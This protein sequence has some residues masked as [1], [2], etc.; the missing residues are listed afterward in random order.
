VS[1]TENVKNLDRQL[2]S[3]YYTDNLSNDEQIRSFKKNAYLVLWETLI[4]SDKSSIVFIIWQVLERIMD[5][6]GVELEMLI[7]LSSQICQVIPRDFARELE[8]NEI[9]E[10]FVK[11]LVDTLNGSMEPS[12]DCPG[13]R[14]VILEQAISL[15]EY[16]SRYASCFKDRR[17]MEALSVVE[18]TASDV[19]KYNLFLGDTGLLEASEPLPRLVARAK[20]LLAAVHSA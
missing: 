6:E 5:A 11:R 1:K 9:K 4:F 17:M 15:L 12:A 19:E 7:G 18:E 2:I 3:T 16:D 8:H 13:I 10:R 14:R 20:Q